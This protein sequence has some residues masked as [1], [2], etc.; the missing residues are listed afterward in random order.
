MVRS[1]S[2]I[3]CTVIFALLALPFAAA[4][5]PTHAS[6][7]AG[8]ITVRD[9]AVALPYPSSLTVT[10]MPT[11]STLALTLQGFTH[12]YPADVDIL[13]VAPNSQSVLVLSD[14]GGSNA[15]SNLRLRF[16]DGAAPATSSRLVSGNYAPTDIVNGAACNPSDAFSAPA[17]G[18]A[19]GSTFSTL[20]GIDPNGEWTLFVRDDCGADV[21]SIACWSLNFGSFEAATPCPPTLSA[22]PGVNPGEVTLSWTT[23]LDGGSAI[24]SYSILRGTSPGS[25]TPLVTVSGNSYTDVAPTGGATYYYA[26]VANNAAGASGQSAEQ[27]VVAGAGSPTTPVPE[28]PTVILVAGGFLAIAAIVVTRRN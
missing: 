26:I 21:G 22:N 14:A 12:S 25:L 4:A 5:S 27:T 9:N 8:P 11:I 17:P 3:T 28:L 7:T 2:I 6:Q 20:N 10:G 16:V 13:L 23:P 18:G 1:P 24:T 19:P 15:V